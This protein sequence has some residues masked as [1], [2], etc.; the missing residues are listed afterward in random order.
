MGGMETLDWNSNCD[1]ARRNRQPR[2]WWRV[3]GDRDVTRRQERPK[4]MTWQCL[5]E[6]GRAREGG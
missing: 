3:L 2:L 1:P 4:Q 6:R 5:A